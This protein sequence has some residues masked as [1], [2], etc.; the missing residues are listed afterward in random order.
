MR[1]SLLANQMIQVELETMY[2]DDF[3]GLS[4][5]LGQMCFYLTF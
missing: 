3:L 1:L 2:L 4:R 5:F